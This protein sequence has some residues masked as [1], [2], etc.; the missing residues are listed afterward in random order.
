MDGD[1][2][3]DYE[4]EYAYESAGSGDDGDGEVA[5]TPAGPKA[6]DVNR[7][8]GGGTSA[9]APSTVSASTVKR[10][11]VGMRPSSS[12]A[13]LS[14]GTPAF[15]ALDADALA[16]ELERAVAGFRDL[17]CVTDDEAYLLLHHAKWRAGALQESWWDESRQ[18]ALR[19]AAGAPP[20]SAAPPRPPPGSQVEDPVQMDSFPVEDCDCGPCGHLFSVATWEE[21]LRSAVADNLLGA[22]TARCPASAD[23]CTAVVPPS[24]WHRRCP[25]EALAKYT[26]QQVRAAWGRQHRLQ[27]G[28]VGESPPRHFSAPSFPVTPSSPA[29]AAALVRGHVPVAGALPGRGVRRRHPVPRRVRV[30]A[31]ERERIAAGCLDSFHP[32][33]GPPPHA[34]ASYRT[35]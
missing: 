25:P 28:T 5:P 9:S 32:H 30:G 6:A 4:L 2:D 8:S 23:G 22:L 17:A 12:G 13:R 1:D 34:H 14:L 20:P 3:F 26:Q 10:L 24:L 31:G 19:A 35:R 27:R 18:A 29:R 11:S 15:V 7:V 21:H 16:D 33:L